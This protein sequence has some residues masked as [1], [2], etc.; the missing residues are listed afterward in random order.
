MI[1]NPLVSLGLA[2]LL[3]LAGSAIEVP[4]GFAVETLATG[5]KEVTAF[6]QAPD[7]RIFLAER[8]G[9]IRLLKEGRLHPDPALALSVSTKDGRGL[10]G[11]VL[12]PDFPH[13]PHLFVLYVAEQ[14]FAHLVLARYKV[15]GDQADPASRVVLL[16]GEDQSPYPGSA[17][18]GAPGGVLCFSPDGTL[19]VGIA[20]RTAGAAGQR[21]D[22]L[23][24]KIYC[25]QP[26]GNVPRW[27]PHATR[28]DRRFH[29][30]FANG[31]RNPSGL[32][33]QPRWEG[34]RVFFADS[35]NGPAEI[36]QLIAGSN[37]SEPGELASV[38]DAKYC[39]PLYAD[40]TGSIA[41]IA[42]GKIGRA[43]V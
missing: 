37:Y 23:Q 43:H 18:N 36:N 27:N 4:K 7:G 29:Y 2:C 42:G 11:V 31:V 34:G 26:D 12:A 30:V 16:E 1:P 19:L 9:N 5:L 32:A 8:T 14:P 40:W 33:V 10:I 25:L 22:T 21:A 41:D 17:T 35:G 6:T 38:F 13:P 15:D 3:G 20:D 28:L 24:G 39:E